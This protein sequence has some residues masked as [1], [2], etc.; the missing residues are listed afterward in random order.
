LIAPAEH[1]IRGLA[2]AATA[3]DA[4]INA[5][6]K[7]DDVSVRGPSLLPGWTRG[8]VVTHL[9]RNADA[10]LNLLIWA[11]TGVE[12]PMYAS[13]A[14]RDADIEEG[15]ARGYLLLAEDLFAACDR[16]RRAADEMPDSAWSAGLT[17]ARG[18]AIRAARVP[19]L[20]T[21][22]VWLH[23]VDLDAGVGLDAIPGE[24]IEQLLDEVV[25][26]YGGRT[27][28][29]DIAVRAGLPDGRWRSWRL[30]DEAAQAAEDPG[31]GE[32]AIGAQ[33][34]SGSGPAVLAWLTGRR[35][36][37]LLTPA[38]PVLPPWA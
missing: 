35:G 26:E 2:A 29:P 30:G 16:F 20:R 25:F 10:L 8:H 23:L 34:V 9:A 17:T 1:A 6:D 5:V 18:A 21:R 32:P 12:H 31:S 15:A 36:G 24:L 3:T 33:T 13:R 19:W 22:E 7:L 28:V 14:D 38:P 4:L 37:E 27:D 11:R